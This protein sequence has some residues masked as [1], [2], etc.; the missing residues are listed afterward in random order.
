[1]KTE[2]IKQR[3]LQLRA[4][5]AELRKELKK[6]EIRVDESGYV[7]VLL[8]LALKLSSRRFVWVS[9]RGRD[10]VVELRGGPNGKI[11]YP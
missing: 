2:E 1:M 8:L 10:E 4:E 7:N 6:K 11:V 5:A 9:V 3:L